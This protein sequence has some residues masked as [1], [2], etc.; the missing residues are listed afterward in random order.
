MRPVLASCLVAFFAA[1][2][3]RLALR[4][5]PAS[6]TS[7]PMTKAEIRETR[8]Q[9]YRAR[10]LE[11]SIAPITS[12]RATAERIAALV[13]AY[14]DLRAEAAELAREAAIARCL[15]DVALVQSGSSWI[16]K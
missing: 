10:S 15:G 5:A 1:G 9:L 6:V 16:V 11:A 14:G 8:A 3:V 7:W 12:D 13:N 4:E 2:S